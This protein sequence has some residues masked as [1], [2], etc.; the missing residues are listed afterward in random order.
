M[1]NQSELIALFSTPLY[2]TRIEVDPIINEDFLKT[3]PYQ[4]YP[5]KTGWSSQ[6]CQI[7]KNK[8]FKSIGSLKASKI[9]YYLF[10]IQFCRNLYGQKADVE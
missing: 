3:I 5:D 10:G 7:L 1:Q 4:P 2:K 8:N 6:D 9:I